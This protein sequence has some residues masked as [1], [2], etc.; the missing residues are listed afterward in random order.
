[1]VSNLER[2]LKVFRDNNKRVFFTPHGAQT[3]DG[4]D[5][6]LHRRSH[7]DPLQPRVGLCDE[8]GRHHSLDDD[9]TEA[10][11]AN[12][13]T[14]DNYFCSCRGKTVQMSSI[15]SGSEVFGL[16]LQ[17]HMSHSFIKILAEYRHS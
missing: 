13:V 12:V 15:E 7:A 11:R 16:Y 6:V 17:A 9:R 5:L 2:M 1:M 14:P 10:K 8:Y 3:S 4:G